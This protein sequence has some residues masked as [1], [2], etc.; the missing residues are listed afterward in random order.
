[1]S[2]RLCDARDRFSELVEKALTEGPQHVTRRGRPAVVVI[3]EAE[4]QTLVKPRR[5][6][7]E[8]LLSA[9]K[10]DIEFERVKVP[11]RDVDL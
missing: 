2:W 10:V 6:L 4:Y 11:L 8:Y 3:S 9:P 7:A 5:S 1:M